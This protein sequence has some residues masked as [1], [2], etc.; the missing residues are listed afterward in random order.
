MSNE[1]ISLQGFQIEK[2]LSDG[3]MG[4]VYKAIQLS[5][6]R[7]V[8]IKVLKNEK[9][10]S[11]F[12]ELLK[13]E[14]KTLAQVNHVNV[15]Q[16]YD[17]KE[18]R[19]LLYIVMELIL[20][21][22]LRDRYKRLGPLKEDVALDFMQQ[23][24]EGLAAVHSIGVIHRDVKPANLLLTLDGRVKV[25]DFGIAKNFSQDST[26]L[27]NGLMGTP[28]YIAPE[29]L[30]EGPVDSR[31][32]VYALAATFYHL[33]A[34]KSP[35]DGEDLT[36]LLSSRLTEV[37]VP[38]NEVC[39][40]ISTDFSELISKML[41]RDVSKRPHNMVQVVEECQR[42]RLLSRIKV[43]DSA[44]VNVGD[45]LQRQQIR[46]LGLIKF[47]MVNKRFKSPVLSELLKRQREFS[48]K[49]Q[50]MPLEKIVLDNN[51]LSKEDFLKLRKDLDDLIQHDENQKILMFL[52]KM[53][54]EKSPVYKKFLRVSEQSGVALITLLE[55]ENV[56]KKSEVKKLIQKIENK[57]IEDYETTLRALLV[58]H[59]LITAEQEQD[60]S[61]SRK[62]TSLAHYLIDNSYV[63]VDELMAIMDVQ[64][65]RCLQ[66]CS[67][68]LFGTKIGF[69]DHVD[70]P[71]CGQ[72]IFMDDK[73][74]PNCR[75]SPQQKK[76]DRTRSYH[77]EELEVV[78]NIQS[79]V[80]EEEW[81]VKT[82]K[83]D[84]GPYTL[85][86]LLKWALEKK[87]SIFAELRK[88]KTGDFKEAGKVPYVARAFGLCFKC[89]Q[90]RSKN[91]GPCPNC[92]AEDV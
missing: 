86:Q 38:L 70:C 79:D 73:E 46:E 29:Q 34:G 28:N 25:S 4:S 2:L 13:N 16:I 60:I 65:T 47:C 49:G 78:D 12:I 62:I 88:G 58:E 20:G 24:A 40:E 92:R 68:S 64:K 81:Y 8:A 80:V 36:T 15:V 48:R 63:E 91:K 41:E 59:K 1:K 32:D 75:K 5:V 44:S 54:S 45:N 7:L 90:L 31:A 30:T 67:H 85:D 39:K 3:G 11:K 61:N 69:R 33:I 19:G 9:K 71:H 66:Q 42:I 6:D 53:I 35:F 84:A 52:K 89:G 55:M 82:K 26:N 18:E 10:S 22:D 14:A 51:F 50:M 57:N 83:G 27:N 87:I 21:A 74:C 17:L 72:Q 37:C 56:L 76:S 43:E 23:S 77:L